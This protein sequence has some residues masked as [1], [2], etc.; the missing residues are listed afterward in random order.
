MKPFYITQGKS[1]NLFFEMNSR[2]NFP[3]ENTAWFV[4]D[5]INYEDFVKKN[6]N[7]TTNSNIIKEW[8]IVDSSLKGEYDFDS[9]E[10]W[11]NFFKINSLWEAII[12][13]RRLSLNRLSK[14]FLSYDYAF[15]HETLVSIV[16][17]HCEEFDNIFRKFKP[18]IIFSFGPNT[19]GAVIS[20]YMAKS[21][22]VPFL[23]LKSTKIS[24][25]VSFSEDWNDNHMHIIKKFKELKKK[26]TNESSASKFAKLFLNSMQ[27]DSSK[28]YEGNLSPKKLGTT[29]L[30]KKYIFNLI[31]SIF[32]DLN[33]L[34][35]G[36]NDLQRP[37]QISMQN[38]IIF[39]K[40]FR[41]LKSKAIISKKLC[42]LNFLKNN[43]YIFFPLNSEPEIALSVYNFKLRNQIE[44]CR[45]I[46]EALPL[47]YYLIV[48]EHPRSW[49][50][51]KSSYYKKLSKIP[52][53]KFA[54]VDDSITDLIKYS[55]GVI[56]ISSFVAF[57]ALILNK[58]VA[59]IG[60]SIYEMLGK[61]YI[62]KVENIFCLD[63]I[64]KELTNLKINSQNILERF[65][66][67]IYETCVPI[68]LYNKLLKKE[69]RSFGA[70]NK[71]TVDEKE[72]YQKLASY[73]K[74]RFLEVSK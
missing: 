10:K 49:G 70:G 25:F 57:Q 36:V 61:P 20:G 35:N 1:L 38:Q 60:S 48:K 18:N 17:K 14:A 21:Y 23:T 72:Q 3:K 66:C 4:T 69:N 29:K 40:F 43:N 6:I 32:S 30:F 47:N 27:K 52:N 68:D 44:I 24:N 71:L 65:I 22:N 26:K 59:L 34:I 5:A 41:K 46:S 50:I 63:K 45:I 28:A 8:E 9:I 2:F 31:K 62:L 51:R 73:A 37:P 33:N 74:K 64:I 19:C 39:G 67:S 54:K 7:F 11:E 15:P 42:S 56:V 12:A 16:N 53:L 58:P 55:S 13:D